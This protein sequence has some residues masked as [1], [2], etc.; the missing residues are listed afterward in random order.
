MTTSLDK[1]SMPQDQ[2]YLGR[3]PILDAKQAIVTG[4][5]LTLAEKMETDNFAVA[6]GLQHKHG[7]SMADLGKVRLEVMQWA[8][9]LGEHANN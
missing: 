2:I 5:L 1:A 6:F 8:A 4:D 3:Q 9:N 7:L